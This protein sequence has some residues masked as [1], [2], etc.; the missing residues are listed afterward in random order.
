[1][2]VIT[3]ANR[4]GG[5]G[6][7][8]TS[9]CLASR[10]VQLGARVLCL[11]LDGQPFN[12]SA[13]AGADRSAAGTWDLLSAEEP[14]VDDVLSCAQPTES[15]GDIVAADASIDAV[16]TVLDRRFG[17][18][19][20]LERALSLVDDRYDYAVLDTPPSLW[21]RTVAALVAADD[22]VVPATASADGSSGALGVIDT[23]A[24]VR[25]LL[26]ASRE[27]ALEVA[28]VVVVDWLRTN[29]A[30]RREA[31]LRKMCEDREVRVFGTRVRHTVR[32]G[33]AQ[34]SCESV[35]V[36]DPSATASGDYRA[37][38]EEYLALP[39]R[40]FRVGQ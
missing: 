12:L 6:K 7:T 35:L 13:I 28:G 37:L 29:E 5:V 22:V 26:G 40:D 18:E 2:R 25:R 38:T 31:Q 15:F 1:M 24:K 17:K 11:D 19:H 10:L 36:A 16:D 9:A 23:A 21:N 30:Q 14:T 8:T 27:R 34:G 39:G 20:V 3:V 32:V 33:A 4:K